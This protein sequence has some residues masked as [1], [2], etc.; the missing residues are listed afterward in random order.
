MSARGLNLLVFREGRRDL[1]GLG[2]KLALMKQLERLSRDST[3]DALIEALLRAGELEC[4]LGDVCSPFFSSAEE[5]TSVLAGALLLGRL[6]GNFIEIKNIVAGISVPERISVSTPEGFAYYALHPLAYAEAARKMSV[7]PAHVV[8][9]GIRSIGTTL[10]AMAAAGA[11]SRGAQVKRITVRP[12]GHPYNRHTDFSPDQLACIQRS[13]SLDAA[14]LVVDE[15]PGLSGSSL[16]S[17]AEAL[18]AAGVPRE[19]I[20]LLCGHEP[21]IEALCSDNAA[22]RWSRYRCL[23]A[24]GEARKPAAACDFVGAGQW[25]SRMFDRESVWPAIWTSLERLK[26][27]SPDDAANPRLYKFAGLGHYGESVMAR[28][29]RVAEAGFG[30]MPARESD[31]F[32]SY[33]WIEGRPMQAGDLNLSRDTIVRLAEYCAFRAREFA[34]DQADPG[35]LRAMAQHNLGQLGAGA[36][37]E[38]SFERLVIADGRMQPHEWLRT[39]SGHMLKTDSGGHGDDH[40]FPGPVDIAWD[41]AGAIVEWRMDVTHRAEFLNAYRAASGDDPSRRIGDFI[42]AYAVF[43]SAYCTMAANAMKGTPEQARLEHAAQEYQEQTSAPPALAAA[44]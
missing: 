18:E 19:K 6:P 3:S 44:I 17:A 41:L 33:P 13:A 20:I 1:S 28:E 25:R 29:L 2:L 22:E 31:G 36:P 9:V 14:F 38:L 39:S 35:P 40:F 8:V 32:A 5:L 34:I 15:G 27:L 30:P 37:I 42:R 21:K 16:L 11:A 10:S 24:A 26:Y 12:T 23:P 43:R 7:L 4:G